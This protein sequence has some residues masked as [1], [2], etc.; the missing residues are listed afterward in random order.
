MGEAASGG[1]DLTDVHSL[2]PLIDKLDGESPVVV[3]RGVPDGEPLV[4]GEGAGPGAED[5]PVP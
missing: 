1:R 4:L 5:V 2:V 3:A